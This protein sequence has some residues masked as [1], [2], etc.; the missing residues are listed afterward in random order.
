MEEEA[1]RRYCAIR[2]GRGQSSYG[3]RR[4]EGDSG[5]EGDRYGVAIGS[6]IGGIVTIEKTHE[7]LMKSGPRRALSR[8]SFREVS[9]I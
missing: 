1:S 5:A 3:R 8:S 6:G 9:S 2:N 7:T 4:A